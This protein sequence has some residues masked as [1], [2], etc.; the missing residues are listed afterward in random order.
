MIDWLEK[1][2]ED[3]VVA[4]PQE[5]EPLIFG[6]NTYTVSVLGRQ[7]RCQ[8][9]IIDA[10]LWARNEKF[11]FVLVVECK[12]KHEKGLAVEQVSR[13]IAAVEDAD[14]YEG[15]PD[16]AFPNWKTGCRGWMQH[17]T[18]KTL[19][20]IVAPSFSDQL[21]ATYTGILI[22]AEKVGDKFILNRK[23]GHI[24]PPKQEQLD[25]AL[26]PVIQRAQADAKGRAISESF[27]HIQLGDMFRR[28]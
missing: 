18:I 6:S 28:N 8:Y 16:D 10:L 7:V 3:Y 17:I 13:Y 25:A 21:L 15:L 9:G 27:K 11:S 5:F 24:R 12:A 4:N 22:A 20:V 23:D 19:P 14:M 26:F 1:E 2:L